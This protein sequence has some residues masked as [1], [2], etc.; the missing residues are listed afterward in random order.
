MASRQN[1]SQMLNNQS[2]SSNSTNSTNAK[3][4]TGHAKSDTKNKHDKNSSS[5]PGHIPMSTN[6]IINSMNNMSKRKGTSFQITSVSVSSGNNQ[7]QQQQNQQQQRN[8]S[9]NNN[10]DDSADDL[11]ESHTD[12]N[13]SRI[14]DYET[15]SFSEDTFSREDV[16]FTQPNA[17]GTA[18]VIPTSSQYGLAIVGP[19]LGGNGSNLT[20][21]H[22]SVTDAGINIMGQIPNKQDVDHKNERFKVVKIESTEPFKRGRWMLA[23]IPTHNEHQTVVQNQA[24]T[25]PRSQLEQLITQE[26]SITQQSSL[27][28]AINVNDSPPNHTE[29]TSSSSSSDT[30]PRQAS[31]I[32]QANVGSSI[33]ANQLT[34]D[35]NSFAMNHP[36]HAHSMTPDMI[37]RS[38]HQETQQQQIQQQGVTLPT[39]ILMQ[40]LGIDQQQQ[41]QSQQQ[42]PEQQSQSIN[43]SSNINN[44]LPPTLVSPMSSKTDN[45]NLVD[46]Q[47]QQSQQD[48]TMTS[49]VASEL[50]SNSNNTTA[51][52]DDGQSLNEDSERNI[53]MT[54][55]V[56]YNKNAKRTAYL[57]YQKVK[58]AS[59]GE[60]KRKLDEVSESNYSNRSLNGMK[61]SM[62]FFEN[63]PRDIFTNLLKTDFL[64]LDE[65]QLES[66]MNTEKSNLMLFD[67]FSKSTTSAAVKSHTESS[68]SG[69]S[70]AGLSINLSSLGPLYSTIRSRNKESNSSNRVSRAASPAP[71]NSADTFKMNATAL[72]CC[73]NNYLTKIVHTNESGLTESANRKDEMPSALP[74]IKPE[75]FLNDR[76]LVA[77]YCFIK[78]FIGASGTSAVAIDNK[79]EQAMDLVKSHLMFAVREEVEVLKEKIAELMDRIN[80]LEVENTIL[81][82]NAS[83]E[84]LSQLSTAATTASTQSTIQTSPAQP[85]SSPALS[86][87]NIDVSVLQAAN[88][89]AAASPSSQTSQQPSTTPPTQN[90]TATS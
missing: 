13:I 60:S 89:A 90:P 66:E 85:Q 70:V 18:P 80:Q 8:S 52:G 69:L 63:V 62:K 10:G 76:S 83:Q 43:A 72:N 20:D 19:D 73:S 31:H 58:I 82:A 42:Q 86:K 21:V 7:Q 84:T 26:N 22:V 47:Q 68:S 25:M 65:K 87:I 29:N 16:F 37:Q 34:T 32:N 30:L 38:L 1:S 14:T 15:P 48:L 77:V 23:S 3:E 46:Q 36:H 6:S 33:Q 17:F 74:M 79:I 57:P 41:P 64:N 75:F 45:N 55:N 67:Q 53:T 88:A 50:S 54:L 35:N 11:D 78:N 2:S 56:K 40:N 59:S 28:N 49:H 61:S 39:N 27:S 24:Q 71:G 81:K 4:K 51:I 5:T 44:N 9:E 12:D